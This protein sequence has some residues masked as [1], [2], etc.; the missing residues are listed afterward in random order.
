MKNLGEPRPGEFIVH[1][2]PSFLQEVFER[3]KPVL[4]PARQAGYDVGRVYLI[5]DELLSNV[6][7]HGYGCASGQPIGVSVEIRDSHCFMRIRDRA[8]LFDSPLHARH[9]ALPAP[10]S[11]APGGRGLVIVHRMC[12]T[13]THRA[14]AEGGNELELVLNMVRRSRSQ[15]AA[16]LRESEPEDSHS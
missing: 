8:P 3:L 14:G 1:T 15:S 12:P 13:F 2:S 11:G 16:C 6:Y 9:R 4:Q 10:E 5:L 7:R